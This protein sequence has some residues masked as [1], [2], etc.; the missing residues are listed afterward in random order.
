MQGS[1][2]GRDW[3]FFIMINDWLFFIMINDLSVADTTLGKYVDDTAL[4]ESERD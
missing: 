4:V 3:L 1:H 2:R